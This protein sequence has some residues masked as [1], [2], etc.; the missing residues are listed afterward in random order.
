MTDSSRPIDPEVVR[1]QSVM[2]EHRLKIGEVL[3]RAGVKRATWWRWTQG[4]EPRVSNLR[5]V[6]AAVEAKVEEK[7]GRDAAASA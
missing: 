1:I 5:K 7:V 4:S 2:F 3:N 6:A